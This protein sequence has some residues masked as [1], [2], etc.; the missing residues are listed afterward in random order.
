MRQAGTL[1]QKGQEEGGWRVQT[2]GQWGLLFR[3][4][5][6]SQ[7]FSPALSPVCA[8]HLWLGL[9]T[10]QQPVPGYPGVL[11][12]VIGQPRQAPTGRH[13]RRDR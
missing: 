3:K 12:A 13:G 5:S 9:S 7:P 8:W 2:M 11:S 6:L 4:L 1:L 10:S